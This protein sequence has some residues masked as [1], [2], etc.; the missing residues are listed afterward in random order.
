VNTRHEFW[1]VAPDGEERVVEFF[2]SAVAVREGQIVTAI[3]GGRIDRQNGPYLMLRNN[4]AQSSDWLISDSAAL[5]KRM[6]LS[7]P[8]VKFTLVGMAATVI[9]W[10]V[11]HTWIL[12]LLVG[13][14]G[15]IIGV[16]KRKSKA[17]AIREV[18]AEAM[19]LEVESFSSRTQP[20]IAEAVRGT[21]A[22]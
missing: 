15:L 8:M 17:G 20:P 13:I 1:L 2:N 9:L 4:N 10:W 11:A 6:G 19:K 5:L 14:A 16:L 21:L 12:G 7:D 22:P 3:W 18:V